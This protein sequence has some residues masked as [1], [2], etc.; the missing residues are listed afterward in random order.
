MST[1][2]SSRTA[3]QCKVGRYHLQSPLDVMNELTNAVGVAVHHRKR[4][5]SRV[6]TRRG[7]STVGDF[8]WFLRW[9]QSRQQ[10]MGCSA[11]SSKS[12][13]HHLLSKCPGCVLQGIV[14]RMVDC[15]LRFLH[16]LYLLHFFIPPSVT[17][18]PQATCLAMLPREL[19]SHCPKFNTLRTS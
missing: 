8:S 15:S 16:G 9:A 1:P 12:T 18:E 11:K 6:R 19:C 2:S 17:R 5:R 10:R 4:S 14:Y 13:T 7:L 3:P